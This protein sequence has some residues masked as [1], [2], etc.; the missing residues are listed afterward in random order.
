MN[1]KLPNYQINPHLAKSKTSPK[2]IIIK[3]QNKSQIN[4]QFSESGP[5]SYEVI[6]P[7]GNKGN[8]CHDGFLSELLY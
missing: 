7:S 2:L 3:S 6:F 5:Q 8:D 4:P 1:P